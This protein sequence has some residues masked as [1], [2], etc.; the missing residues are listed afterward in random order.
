M[1]VELSTEERE[2]IIG[3]ADYVNRGSKMELQPNERNL[4]EKL[5]GVFE[6]RH[7]VLR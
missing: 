5:G 4:V 7:I 3:W 6:E 2:I 1:K